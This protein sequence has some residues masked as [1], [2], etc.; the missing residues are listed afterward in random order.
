MRQGPRDNYCLTVDF[1]T[2]GIPT[3]QSWPR[4]GVQVW[5]WGPSPDSLQCCCYRNTWEDRT[6]MPNCMAEQRRCR[7]VLKTRGEKKTRI[8]WCNF[9]SFTFGHEC[10]W[11]LGSSTWAGE[12]AL[13]QLCKVE[14]PQRGRR[15]TLSIKTQCWSLTQPWRQPGQVTVT[16][17]GVGVE[18][19]ARESK[20]NS[21]KRSL[22]ISL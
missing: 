15:A 3:S 18:T 20:K 4:G 11:S 19:T 2:P 10:F 1:L 22:P 21:V 12:V 5:R 9:S 6:Q 8:N 7:R 16:A 17:Q 14:A 13:T